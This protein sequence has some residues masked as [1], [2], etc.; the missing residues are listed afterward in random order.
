MGYAATL[1]ALFGHGLRG[2]VDDAVRSDRRWRPSASAG[3]KWIWTSTGRWTWMNLPISSASGRWTG[4]EGSS[5][6]SLS[7]FSFFRGTSG[8]WPIPFSYGAVRVD[9]MM[10]YARISAFSFQFWDQIDQRFFV[11]SAGPAILA[12]SPS[13]TLRGCWACDV[14]GT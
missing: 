11:A 5:R 10:L 4:W 14:S 2:W 13:S 3:A 1:N 7:V 9:N 12:S 6:P 8:V